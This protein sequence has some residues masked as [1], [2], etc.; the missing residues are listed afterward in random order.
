MPDGIDLPATATF[1]EA[2]GVCAAFI[3]YGRFYLQWIVSE[4]RKE[5]VVPIGFWYMSALGSLMLL[6]YAAYLRSPVGA[7]SHT[8]NI[9]I[10]ARN[11]IHIWRERG[12]LSRRRNIIVHA[13]MGAVVLAAL[14]LLIWT[15][16][17]EYQAT[18]SINAGNTRG[19]WLWIGI[20]VLGQGLFGCRFLVQWIAT[21]RA[22]KSVVPPVFWYLSIVAACLF[23]LS[24]VQ[25]EEWVFVAGVAT[26]IPIYARNI[27]FVRRGVPQEPAG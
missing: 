4:R 25:R 20:G 23:L 26:T 22:R 6:V 5:S 18:Q 24:F 27:W 19:T 8:F 12:T 16:A 1:F 9:V 11:L 14:A 13:S 15:W 2:M 3:F 21:E 17:R 7:L 10:Y